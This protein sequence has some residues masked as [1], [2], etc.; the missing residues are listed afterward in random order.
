[1]A[2]IVCP[3]NRLGR[4]SDFQAGSG[5]YVRGMYIYAS[6]VGPRQ[7]QASEDGGKPFLIVSDICPVGIVRFIAIHRVSLIFPG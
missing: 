6:V 2:D 4:A 7:E 1:M 5:T 3:G